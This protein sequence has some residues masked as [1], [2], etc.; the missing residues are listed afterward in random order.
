MVL[1]KIGHVRFHIVNSTHR[2]RRC[3]LIKIYRP[4]RIVFTLKKFYSVEA[5]RA[6]QRLRKN[7]FGLVKMTFGLAEQTSDNISGD[8]R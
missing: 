5:S 7:F 6:K 3:L 1:A 4:H 8:E 2:Y